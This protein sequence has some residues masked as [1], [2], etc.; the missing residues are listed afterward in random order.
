MRETFAGEYA[1]MRVGFSRANANGIE[2][3][4]APA[5]QEKGGV[6]HG[7]TRRAGGVSKPPFH[8]LNLGWNRDE[9]R[10]NIERNFCLLAQAAG[11]ERESMAL[12]NYEHGDSVVRA[13]AIDRGKGMGKDSGEFAPCDALITDSDALTLIT[14]HADCMPVFLYDPN[15]RAVGMVHAGWK[16]V[17]MRIGAKAVRKMV[18]ELGCNAKDM[19]IGCGPSITQARFEVEQPVKE[20]FEREFPGID[21]VIQGAQAGKYHIDLYKAMALQLLEAGVFPQNITLSLECTYDNPKNYY[22]YRRDQRA[23]GAMAG[24]IRLI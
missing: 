4:Y 15:A 1:K 24:F 8:A 16:G 20:V 17:S 14:L 22:S 18:D 12:V 6:A 21:C 19:Y 7:F 13:A 11:F 3:V 10:E 2:W 5:L 23:S 9:P